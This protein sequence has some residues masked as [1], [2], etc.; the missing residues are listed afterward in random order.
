MNL[1]LQSVSFVTDDP[2]AD[3]HLAAKSRLFLANQPLA[4]LRRLIISA[5][6]GLVT[7]DGTVGSYYERQL[8]VACVQRVAGVRRVIDHIL[9]VL[10]TVVPQGECLNDQSPVAL[11]KTSSSRDDLTL[12]IVKSKP[13]EL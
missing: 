13:N 12:A 7:V 3:E 11:Q 4:A 2:V 6:N 5:R 1:S 8:A 9:V 10:E